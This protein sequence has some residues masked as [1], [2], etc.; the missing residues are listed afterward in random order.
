MIV[1]G[2]PGKFSRLGSH[3][4][5][6]SWKFSII[7]EKFP[8]LEFWPGKIQGL[9]IHGEQSLYW[10]AGHW[11]KSWSF[12]KNCQFSSFHPEPPWLRNWW[13]SGVCDIIWRVLMRKWM[14]VKKSEQFWGWLFFGKFSKIFR[15]L[16]VRRKVW[17]FG[18]SPFVK[19]ND[20]D[21]SWKHQ[22]MHKYSSVQHNTCSDCS[23]T[24]WNA[25]KAWNPCWIEK[26]QNRFRCIWFFHW[27]IK[28]VDSKSIFKCICSSESH[29]TE[30]NVTN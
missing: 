8:I 17:D 12:S 16:K 5:N 6:L 9:T 21:S 20:G 14:R 13:Q 27:D 28:V 2:H 3:L 19:E 15:A 18:L 1:F 11:N 24:L 25:F 23:A 26:V 10:R 22:S 4:G 7:L 29:A 30:R